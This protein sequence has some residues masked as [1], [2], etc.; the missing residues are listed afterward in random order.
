MF[1]IY[2]ICIKVENNTFVLKNNS[3]IHKNYKYTLSH[4]YFSKSKIAKINQ[5]FTVLFTTGAITEAGTVAMATVSV[6]TVTTVA[7]DLNAFHSCHLE[8]SWEGFSGAIIGK[9]KSSWFFVF[10][11]QL[12][13]LRVLFLLFFIC[14]RTNPFI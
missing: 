12:R 11:K 2:A 6:I 1:L 7:N 3:V 5:L 14:G 13:F 9:F 8:T 10:T 4:K